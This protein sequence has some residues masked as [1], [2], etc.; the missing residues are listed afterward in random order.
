MVKHSTYSFLA[1]KI[2]YQLV[3]TLPQILQ[4]CG[5]QFWSV[6]ISVLR[7]FYTFQVISDT[8]PHLT[9]LFLRKHYEGILPVLNVHSF[10]SN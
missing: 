9:T 5:V 6:L 4:S 3:K 7:L 10:P 1:I 2:P 8:V